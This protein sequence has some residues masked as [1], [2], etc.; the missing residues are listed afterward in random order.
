MI[1]ITGAAGFIGSNLAAALE[2]RGEPIVVCDHMGAGD[3]WRNLR[4]REL[5][6]FVAPDDLFEYLDSHRGDVETIYHLGAISSTTE[7]DVDLIMDVNVRLSGQ[8]W[9]WCASNQ[10]N[11]IYASSAATYGGG[12][13][14]FGDDNELGA[15]AKLEPLNPYGW[16]KHVFD[17][18]VVRCV[19]EGRPAPPHWA[20]LKFF[21]VYGPNE[22]HKGG[23]QS[24]VP[25]IYEQAT[26]GGMARLFQSHHPDYADGGQMRD[27]IWVGDCV[28]VMTWLGDNAAV[29]G[30]FNCGTGTAR[31]FLDLA[32][33]V[34]AALERPANIHYIPT[35]EHIR[36]KYQYFTEARMDR[37]RAA[38]YK[39]E[40]TTLEDG[41]GR[42]V[43]DY[44]SADDPFL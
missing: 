3:K 5:A 39:A 38:G 18:Q 8:L 10:A 24:V 35:P 33:A 30:I 13:A 37:L 34:F 21:N 22:Y 15:M 14:G 25:Q 16:S 17:R 2:K 32:N 42:Y 36:D 29:N 28:D 9:D 11:F 19:A 27:F 20:G 12:E 26:H 40:F 23:Q 43:T 44:L 7:T 31:S 6:G 4:A 41:V 1:V